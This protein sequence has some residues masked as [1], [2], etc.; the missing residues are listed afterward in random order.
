MIRNIM[1]YDSYGSDLTSTTKMIVI[2]EDPYQK[3]IHDDD[4]SAKPR[5]IRTEPPELAQKIIH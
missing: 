4:D 5:G 1:K 2:S 3:V